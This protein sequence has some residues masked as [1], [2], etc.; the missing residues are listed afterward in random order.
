MVSSRQIAKSV[1]DLTLPFCR[2]KHYE[3]FPIIERDGDAVS[4][5][6]EDI[7]SERSL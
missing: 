2:I 5:I 6:I 7:H 1:F 4:R 3:A